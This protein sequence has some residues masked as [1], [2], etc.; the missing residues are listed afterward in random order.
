MVRIIHAGI[1]VRSRVDHDAVNE[2]IDYGGDGVDA[3]EALVKCGGRT[4]DQIIL[5]SRK[6]AS[7]ILGAPALKG[8]LVV[9]RCFRSG[10]SHTEYPIIALA[11]LLRYRLG[12]EAQAEV[13]IGYASEMP[14]LRT[15]DRQ[16]LYAL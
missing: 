2:V 1:R 5:R 9:F 11:Q 10:E 8:W 6:V 12:I 3:A 16:Q 7:T 14:I 4:Q 15:R 13:L